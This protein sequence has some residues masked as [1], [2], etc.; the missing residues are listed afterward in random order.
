MTQFNIFSIGNHISDGTGSITTKCNT[1]G[2][3]RWKKF[4][5]K[6]PDNLYRSYVDTIAQKID[7]TVYY[8]GKHDSS[9]SQILKTF[10]N[11]FPNI[12]KNFPDDINLYFLNVGTIPYSYA[13][14]CDE[15]QKFEEPK[16]RLDHMMS[17]TNQLNEDISELN[18][19][20]SNIN[21]IGIDYNNRVVVLTPN[22]ELFKETGLVDH[23]IVYGQTFDNFCF[24]ENPYKYNRQVKPVAKDIWDYIEFVDADIKE[25]LKGR[26]VEGYFDYETQQELGNAL[27]LRLTERTTMFII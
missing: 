26:P 19:F 14:F 15:Q 8:L 18:T 1:R 7:A 17:Y 11:S 27:Y 9:F 22:H 12:R 2:D 24:K 25:L 5:Q 21:D 13:N 16:D 20:A 3:T 4:I 10:K 6:H 23:S